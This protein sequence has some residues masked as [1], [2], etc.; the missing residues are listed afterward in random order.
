MT[1]PDLL[2]LAALALLCLAISAALLASCLRVIRAVDDLLLGI[3][4]WGISIQLAYFAVTA[5]SLQ[6]DILW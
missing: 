5:A 3:L 4:L 1:P 2:P 6:L